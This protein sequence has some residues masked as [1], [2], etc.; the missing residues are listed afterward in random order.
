MCQ[1]PSCDLC[2]VVKLAQLNFFHKCNI[3]A[4]SCRIGINVQSS[5]KLLYFLTWSVWRY[6]THIQMINADMGLGMSLSYLYDISKEGKCFIHRKLIVLNLEYFKK[7]VSKIYES[8][9]LIAYSNLV[10][11]YHHLQLVKISRTLINS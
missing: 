7:Y 1:V 10:L 4:C 2:L 5:V 8:R 6:A 11:P 3:I 9:N